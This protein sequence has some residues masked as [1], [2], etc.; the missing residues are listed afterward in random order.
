MLNNLVRAGF[1]GPLHL[2]SRTK[3]E[4][5]GRSCVR[6]IDDLPEGVDAL[7][8]MVPAEAVLDWVAAC[9]RRKVNG[10]IIFSSGFAEV[11]DAG[12]AAQKELKAL[13]EKAGI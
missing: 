1:A 11:D 10:V 7:V 8:L 13:A 9:A 3:N 5:L 6:S 2:V 12:K 4:L